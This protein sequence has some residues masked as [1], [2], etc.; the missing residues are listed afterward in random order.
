MVVA[1]YQRRHGLV[2]IIKGNI[3][4]TDDSELMSFDRNWAF[5]SCIGNMP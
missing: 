2:Q 3:L 4:N 1:D 5:D